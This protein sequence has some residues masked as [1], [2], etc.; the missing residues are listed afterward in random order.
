MFDYSYVAVDQFLSAPN[1][2]SSIPNVFRTSKTAYIPSHYHCADKDFDRIN[3][4]HEVADNR[5][6]TAE[7][8][9]AFGTNKDIAVNVRLHK[10]NRC[11][12]YCP[13]GQL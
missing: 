6:K 12:R 5:M 10:A 13:R 11:R 2:L 4:V 8:M 7:N 3:C 9:H 1:A